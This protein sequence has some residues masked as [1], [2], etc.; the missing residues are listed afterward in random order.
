MMHPA[1]LEICPYSSLWPNWFEA[2]RSV[3]ESVFSSRDVRIE[4]VGSTAVPGLGAKPIV[5]ILL[6]AP[7]LS[8]IEAKSS[9]LAALNYQ[10]MPEHEAL[11][12]Q[13]RFFAKPQVR[14]RRFHLHAVERESE[15]WRKHLA[16][17]DALRSDPELACEYERMKHEL[18]VRFGVDRVG[19]T[20][21]KSSF[22]QSVLASARNR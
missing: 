22:I 18:A 8:V 4:H 14:P 11:L 17:R 1:P 20:E 16:F 5:D 12:P 2:E 13:R 21:A 3:L 6:G 15:F 10:Y 9:A 7:S 19:Y